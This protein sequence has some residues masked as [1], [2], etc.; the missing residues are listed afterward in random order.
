MSTAEF[1]L[2]LLA[3]LLTPGPTNTLLALA[4]AERGW[5]GALRLVPLEAAAYALV[6][7]PLAF[8]GGKLLAEQD[9]I[10][11]AVSL[12][13][14]LWV[15]FLAVKLWR[16]P[17]A[18]AM[19]PGAGGAFKLFTTTLCNPKGF[20]IG[21]LL[22][23]SQASMPMAVAI[24]AVILLAASVF[25]TGLGSMMAGGVA[26]TPAA[27]RACAGWLCFMAAWIAAVAFIP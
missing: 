8:A 3:L 22:L 24:F 20:V 10:R 13:A 7:L 26:L 18:Q 5:A 25:W 27:R 2:A 1:A 19:G 12:V 11:V 4:G 14:A 23:P 6:T 17:T 16:L 9:A 15:V 21:L